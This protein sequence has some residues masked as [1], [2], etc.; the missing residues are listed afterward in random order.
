[1][2]HKTLLTWI[3]WLIPHLIINKF[4]LSWYDI[5]SIMN[6]FGNNILT[7]MNM[8]YKYSNVVFNTSIGYND[9]S[10]GII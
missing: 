1:M 8:G 6:G 5:D 3:A 4:Y 9:N 10:L 7:W 2:M